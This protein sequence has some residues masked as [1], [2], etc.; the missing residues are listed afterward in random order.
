MTTQLTF[1][2]LKKGKTIFLFDID[3]TLTA[4]RQSIKEDMVKCLTDI[5][6]HPDFKIASVGGSDESK[7]K[8]QLCQAFSLFDFVFTENGLVSYNHE[9]KVFHRENI[10]KHYKEEELKEFINFCLRYVADLDIPVKRGTFIEFRTGLINISPI[11][12]NCS[13][14]ER[15]AFDK[16]NKEHK[17]LEKFQ[18]IVEEKFAKK[19][20]MKFSIGGQISFDCFPDGWDKTYCL[21]FLKEFDNIVFFG[22]KTD[23]GGNDHEISISKGITRA[24][25]VKDP[26]DTIKKINSVIKE[27]SEL[28]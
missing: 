8:E 17:I 10:S 13:L 24:Y 12:R 14:E 1:N 3:G 11:G 22:D 7:A 15:L 2:P 6:S 16:Y 19:M 26:E 23:I 9:G 21:Q 27:L 28:K 18:K 4:S 5:K 25:H 20:N